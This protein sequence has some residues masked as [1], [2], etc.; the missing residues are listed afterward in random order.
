MAVPA[1]RPWTVD[2][3]PRGTECFKRVGAGEQGW[4]RRFSADVM[5]KYYKPG[6]AFGAGYE[7]IGKF[8]VPPLQGVI[9]D[10]VK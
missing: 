6:C 4:R 8:L 10:G 7:N 9:A 1:G 3:F 2:L 5:R